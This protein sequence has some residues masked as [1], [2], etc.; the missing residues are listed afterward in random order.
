MMGIAL[1]SQ[2][3]SH[4]SQDFSKNPKNS[5]ELL[6][7]ISDIIL[8]TPVKPLSVYTDKLKCGGFFYAMGV[9]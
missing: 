7:H 6:C 8:S 5:L 4:K 2:I 3:K 1:I 9:I